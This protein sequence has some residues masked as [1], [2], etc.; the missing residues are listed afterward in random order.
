ME[1]EKDLKKLIENGYR[2]VL[3][4]NV[5]LELYRYSPDY[6][7]FALECLN[8][9]KD[10]IRLPYTVFLE[11][12]RHHT[13]L[14]KR[15]QKSI[16]TSIEDSLDLVKNQM[17][18]TLSG[19]AV[20]K[21]RNFPEIDSLLDGIKEKYESITNAMNDYFDE[22][23]VLSLIKDN[24]SSDMPEEFVMDLCHNV[25]VMKPFTQDKLYQ[26]CDD[27]EKRY[28]KSIPP[29]FKDA[30]NKDGIRKYS[31]LIL[32]KET[33]HYAQTNRRNVIFVT[34]DLKSDWWDQ[35]T[36]GISFK[37]ELIKEFNKETKVRENSELGNRLKQASQSLDSMTIVPFT[38]ENFFPE[39]SK[40]FCIPIPD[41]IDAGVNLTAE[42]YIENIQNRAF[43]K[44]IDEIKYSGTKYLDNSI[45][46]IGSE[47]IE[48]WDIDDFEYCEYSVED[49]GDGIA[50]YSIAY[51]VSISGTSRD[52]WGR[53]DDTNEIILSG[54]YMHEVAGKVVVLVTRNVDFGIDFE[55]DDDF[56]SVKLEDASFSEV[57]FED[58][59]YEEDMPY[60]FVKG[61]YTTC[62]SCDR[63]INFYN[64]AGNGFC[65]F[66]ENERND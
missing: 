42:T 30:K 29:G 58:N 63:P 20:L 3:D 50:V 65:I 31:D 44:I 16:D 41:A 23:R 45:T 6:A 28:K 2:V 21:K 27:G 47:G 62:P 8:K 53:D 59:S 34:N 54:T 55:S 33:I 40:S 24:W 36:N 10:N 64:D 51:E 9:I 25:Q 61:A 15:R 12:N 22:H 5:L 57:S 11:F 14:Y 19:C 48:S 32:W 66:C 39:M 52:Y 18:K 49:S 56:E 35:D 38:L 26:I 7:D 46:Q 1:D 13:A 4:T 37:T 17:N 43:D 60:E